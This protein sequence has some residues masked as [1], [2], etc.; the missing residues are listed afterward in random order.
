MMSMYDNQ[1]YIMW[2]PSHI[3]KHIPKEPI[4]KYLISLRLNS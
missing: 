1:A 3:K 2:L 4:N